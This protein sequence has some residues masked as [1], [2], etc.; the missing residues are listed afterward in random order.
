MSSMLQKLKILSDRPILAL[1]PMAGYT[2]TAHRLICR[3]FG[4]NLLYTE[5]IS[6]NGIIYAK[7][8]DNQCFQLAKFNAKERPLLIQIFGKDPKIMAEASKIIFN[9]FKPDGIDI[10]MGCP[11]KKEVRQGYGVALMKD[12]KNACKIV[13]QIKCSVNIPVSVK[14]R[15]GFSKPNEIIKF[16]QALE[17]AGADMLCIHGRTYKQFFTGPV[18]YEMIKKVKQKIKIPVIANG[19]INTPEIAKQVLDLTHC[20]GIAIGQASLGKPW[21]FKQINDY[22]LTGEYEEF[23]L[24]KIKTVCLQY[25]KLFKKHNKSLNLFELKKN[26]IYYFK[27]IKDKKYIAEKIFKAE[28]IEALIKIV[29]AI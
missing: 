9:K 22:L 19:G 10:N 23:N 3:Q 27:G 4:A 14:T 16:S 29:N 15:L 21:I 6:A 18:N 20:D 17:K 24:K 8:N 2:H 13:E 11:V 25:I 1:A 26:L 7:S 28:N 12:L 5:L